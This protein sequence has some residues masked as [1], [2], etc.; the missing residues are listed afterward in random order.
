MNGELAVEF[1]IRGDGDN[2]TAADDDDTD[3]EE[4]DLLTIQE[5]EKNKA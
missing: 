3:E 4:S 1:W 5:R 2:V